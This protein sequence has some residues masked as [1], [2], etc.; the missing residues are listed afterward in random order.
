M[1]GERLHRPSGRG[2]APA[3]P[4]KRRPLRGGREEGNQG[5]REPGNSISPVGKQRVAECE[6]YVNG[7][8]R[9]PKRRGRGAGRHTPTARLPRS[10]HQYA[11]RGTPREEGANRGARGALTGDR[12]VGTD[13]GVPMGYTYRGGVGRIPGGTSA[14]LA[15]VP[16]AF[17]RVQHESPFFAREEAQCQRGGRSQSINYNSHVA[18]GGAMWPR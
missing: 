15:P 4:M 8:P 5:L 18:V 16:P 14:P 12:Y 9:A 13:A 6:R 3:S 17:S 1:R 10:H 2:G 7:D 11:G